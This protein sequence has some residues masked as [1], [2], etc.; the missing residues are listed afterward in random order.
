MEPTTNEKAA[1]NRR[2][3]TLVSP[4]RQVIHA[5]YLLSFGI[6]FGSVFVGFSTVLLDAQSVD[7]SGE[8][9]PQSILETVNVWIA[10]FNVLTLFL[11]VAAH[12]G[13][14]VLFSFLITH[15]IYGPLVPLSR[16]VEGLINGDY[17]VRTHLRT[18]DE[19]KDF[20]R[21]LNELSDKL[22]KSSVGR[23]P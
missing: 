5:I 17:T 8:M 21:L 22:A 13:V 1:R 20:A 23:N 19:F 3:I 18:K 9:V 6:V 14:C 15:R 12:L 16:H 11:F 7:P 4:R 2:R 10:P